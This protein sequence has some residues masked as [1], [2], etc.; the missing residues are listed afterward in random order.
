MDPNFVATYNNARAAGI[1]NIDT[2][3]YV[4]FVQSLLALSLF[5]GISHRFPCTGSGNKCKSYAAQ[6]A[7]LGAVF[8]AHKMDIGTIWVG[9][10]TIG[11]RLLSG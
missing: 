3:W 1:T 10:L 2:Y 9:P 7:A 8:Q 4:I 6:I 11:Y 5:Q